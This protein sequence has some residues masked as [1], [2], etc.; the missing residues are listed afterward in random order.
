[1]TRGCALHLEGDVLYV[2]VYDDG[3]RLA[4]AVECT[5]DADVLYYLATIGEVYD[6]Y[7]MYARVTGNTKCMMP[8][9]KRLFKEYICE[10]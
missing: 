3:L 1:M 4:E 5:N 6:I 9:V 2:L 10:L 7:N 8:H